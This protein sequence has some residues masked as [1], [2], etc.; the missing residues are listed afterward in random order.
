MKISVI[1]VV[2]NGA[3]TLEEAILSVHRQT[4]GEI[5][6]I[7]VDGCST[8]GT[9]A[10][11]E[12]HR[13]KLSTV[14]REPDQGLYH[15]MNKGLAL[16][17]GEVVGFLNADDIY[18]HDR[19]LE[20]IAHTLDDPTL[21]ACYADLVYVAKDDPERIV[22]YWTSQP[23][24]DGLF[25]K[26]WL[27]AHPTFYVRRGVY[28]QFGDFDLYYR[29]QA[30][31]E[32]TMRFLAI[33]GIRSR[34]VPEIWVRMRLGGATNRSLGN[35]MR[36]NFESYRA[37]KEHGLK[38]NPGYFATKFLLRLPQFFKRPAP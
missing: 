34:Y 36:G 17:S 13:E 6:H 3:A 22:R 35:V 33:G 29:Y 23:Y 37:C 31:F 1:T 8:D 5:E 19:V 18:S 9:A 28:E 12:R 14:L 32:L 24:E 26:G 27:P 25:E 20:R 21:D 30:D 4:H 15:A 10:I 16:A 38:V 11:V 7:V 2:Y